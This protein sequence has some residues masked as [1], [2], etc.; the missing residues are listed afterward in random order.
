MKNKIW[1]ILAVVA[2]GACGIPA[3]AQDDEA[4]PVEAA[5]LVRSPQRYW[6][7]SFVFADV[8]RLHPS[9]GV[10]KLDGRRYISFSTHKA[11]K[12]YVATELAHVV[13]NL[14]LERRYQ[15]LGT[16]LQHG[17]RFFIIVR[18]VS[19]AVEAGDL[20]LDWPRIT[21]SPSEYM[22]NQA[23]RPIL[24]ILTLT[25]S[26]HVAYAEEKGVALAELYDP[27]APH[28]GQAMG[29]MRSTIM[30]HEQK[31]KLTASEML[32]EYLFQMLVAR[33]PPS[34]KPAPAPEAPAVESAPAV[35]KV[36]PAAELTKPA[37][38]P[39]K[40]LT[41]QELRGQAR[42]KKA[43]AAAEKAKKKRRAAK[44][45]PA[46]EPEVAP[47]AL[48]ETPPAVTLPELPVE[49]GPAEAVEGEMLPAVP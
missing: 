16:V 24:D 27:Q 48:E 38:E 49:S 10:L 22:K 36:S 23:L 29:L 1:M 42:K 6:A 28:Y 37:D 33:H 46:P 15:F 32:A 7:R 21:D 40:R 39:P 3:P 18:G 35:P 26:A 20:K 44:P 45:A 4:K 25:E 5:E 47:V 30:A 8:L 41:R 2:A 17:R 31:V 12:C 43:E 34:E 14:P 13:N 9:G 11:G 19:A